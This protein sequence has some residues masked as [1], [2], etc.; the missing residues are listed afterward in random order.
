MEILKVNAFDY[1]KNWKI[2]IEIARNLYIFIRKFLSLFNINI[3]I[4]HKPRQRTFGITI[5]GTIDYRNID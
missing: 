3:W 2:R 1:E 4:A 5:N